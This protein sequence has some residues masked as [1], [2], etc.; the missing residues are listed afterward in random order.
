MRKILGA[1]L[2]LVCIWFATPALADLDPCRNLFDGV[3]QS[4]IYSTTTGVYSSA[5]NRVS[6]KNMIAVQP[7]TKYVAS[8]DGVNAIRWLFYDSNKAFISRIIL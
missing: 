2:A 3:W 1:A 8:G 7:D 5:E 6:N 4:G